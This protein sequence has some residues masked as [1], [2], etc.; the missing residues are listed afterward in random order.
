MNNINYVELLGLFAGV[1]TTLSFIPQIKK[2]WA[3]KSVK[4]I[5]IHM[6]VIYT[7]GLVLWTI[8][9]VL[10]GSVALILA[11]L[12][13]CIFAFSILVMKLRWDTFAQQEAITES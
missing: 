10:V 1:C 8:Y 2:V 5:S 12:V 3:T 6:Y 7:T 4:D 11:N 9:G 13:T